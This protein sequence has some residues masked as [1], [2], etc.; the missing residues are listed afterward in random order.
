MGDGG[1]G[2]FPV[3]D[4]LEMVLWFD[5]DGMISHANVSARRKLGYE[6][7][8]ADGAAALTG[9]HISDVMP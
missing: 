6:D 9:R 4:A 8:S 2:A 1:I 7:M 5:A 3:E